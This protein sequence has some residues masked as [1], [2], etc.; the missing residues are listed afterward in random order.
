MTGPRVDA[1][2]MLDDWVPFNFAD[3]RAVI[4]GTVS[5]DRKR[6]FRDGATMSASVLS[7]PRPALVAGVIVET[8][9]SRYL[10]GR[11]ETNPDRIRELMI[12]FSASLLHRIDDEET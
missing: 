12:K 4:V 3:G 5:G 9:N 2:A 11:A 1:D 8:A 10:L 7:T 6:R